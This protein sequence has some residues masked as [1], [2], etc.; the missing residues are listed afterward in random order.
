MSAGNKSV[1][2]SHTVFH[3]SDDNSNGGEEHDTLA[4]RCKQ[5][6]SRVSIYNLCLAKIQILVCMWCSWKMLSC[7]MSDGIV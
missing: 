5:S 7:G 3:R 2:I 6:A 4:K 1:C